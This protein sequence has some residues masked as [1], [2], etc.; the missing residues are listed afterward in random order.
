LLETGDPEREA[1]FV[2]SFRTVV[3]GQGQIS[4]FDL[5][6]VTSFDWGV[7]HVFGPYASKEMFNEAVP[8]WI[9]NRGIDF[10][11]DINLLVFEDGDRV[12]LTVEVPRGICDFASPFEDNPWLQHFKV[13]SGNALFQLTV[14]E[15]GWCR[16]KPIDVIRDQSR[17]HIR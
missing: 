14:D 12:V 2:E 10:R 8:W 5:A 16:A 7:V 6:D 13:A 17:E 1:A 11:D 4:Q 9:D 3:R 15:T